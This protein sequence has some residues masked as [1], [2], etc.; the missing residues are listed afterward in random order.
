[1]FDTLDILYPISIPEYVPKKYIP[2][3]KAAFDRSSFQ[4]KDLES[5][6]LHYS[7]DE[8]GFLLDSKNRKNTIYRHTKCLSFGIYYR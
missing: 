5:C 8:S 4:T 2:Y 6:F 3:I 7:I 1:M